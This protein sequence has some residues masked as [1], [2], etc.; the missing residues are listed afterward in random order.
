MILYRNIVAVFILSVLTGCLSDQE[1]VVTL[2][3]WTDRSLKEEAH[4]MIYANEM[5]VGRLTDS[6]HN[7]IC[8]T[9][10]LIDFNIYDAQDLHLTVRSKNGSV[11]DIGVINLYGVSTGIKIRPSTEGELYINQ[12]LDD[13][14][15]LVYLNWAD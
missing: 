7:P 3:F 11:K 10:Q 1:K 5:F 9:S 8:G 14:C 2:S 12:S 4:T 13:I 6:L 15:T